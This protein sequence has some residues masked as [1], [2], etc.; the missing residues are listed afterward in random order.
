MSNLHFFCLRCQKWRLRRKDDF[1]L[2]DLP[3]LGL[4]KQDLPDLPDIFPKSDFNFSKLIK[5]ELRVCLNC[6]N[7]IKTILRLKVVPRKR[8]TPPNPQL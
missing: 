2:S 1:Y 3:D 6:V 7:E 8:E 4:I 5:L